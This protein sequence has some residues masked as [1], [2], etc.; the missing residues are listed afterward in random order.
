MDDDSL[1][2]DR[3]FCDP[4]Q[5]T[6]FAPY[7]WAL[8]VYHDMIIRQATH[9]FDYLSEAMVLKKVTWTKNV[10]FELKTGVFV[11]ARK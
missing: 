8:L 7:L 11:V 5:F 3:G 4:P 6:M 9:D 1:G 10:F 2:D